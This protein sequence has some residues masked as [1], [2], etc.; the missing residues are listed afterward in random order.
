LGAP[1]YSSRTLNIANSGA[2]V[3]INTNFGND[4]V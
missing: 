1:D 3:F 4:A 2:E